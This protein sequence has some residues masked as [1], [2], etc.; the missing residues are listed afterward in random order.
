VIGILYMSAQ[1]RPDKPEEKTKKSSGRK[2]GDGK[3]RLGFK[4]ARGRVYRVDLPHI[5]VP[6]YYWLLMQSLK[7][8]PRSIRGVI[9]DLITH[10]RQAAEAEERGER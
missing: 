8:K 9:M 6:D 2:A 10:A 5:S 7:R 4:K 1:I 3:G